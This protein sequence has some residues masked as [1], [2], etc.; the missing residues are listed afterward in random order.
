MRNC[1]QKVSISLLIFLSAVSVQAGS[2]RDSNEKFEARVERF[3]IA[4]P[5]R[6]Q[7]S[8]E[9]SRGR[10]VRAQDG[11]PGYVRKTYRVAFK[12]GKPVAKELLK[13]ER[14]EAKP[15]IFRIGSAGFDFSRG[16]F[17]RHK[18]LD[19]VATA[20]PAMCCGTG[21][22]RTGRR[23]TYGV[24]AVDPRVI[25]LGSI[26]YVEGYGLALACDTGGAIKGHRID[27]C[28]DSTYLADEYGR[29]HV[30]VHILR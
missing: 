11:Q 23:A 15:V 22:T 21:I 25:P 28:Y 8:R 20:Y 13:E 6:Y 16:D 17:V 18:V 12:D 7:V 9:V 29:H 3:T 19:M 2:K 4:P 5:V 14:T 30:K 24:V 1:S 10:I 26:V 27:L